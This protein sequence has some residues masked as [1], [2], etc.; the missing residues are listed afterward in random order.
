MFPNSNEIDFYTLDAGF[1]TSAGDAVMYNMNGTVVVGEDSYGCDW[2]DL[3]LD[4]IIAIIGS[5]NFQQWAK[6]EL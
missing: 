6:I 2:E 5:E 4:D 1:Y 3:A